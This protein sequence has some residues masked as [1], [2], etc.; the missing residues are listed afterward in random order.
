MNRN[1][2][3]GIGL[4]AAYQATNMGAA[5]MGSIL[6]RE[7]FLEAPFVPQFG[8]TTIL[9]MMHMGAQVKG[10]NLAIQVPQ[11]KAVGV[12]NWRK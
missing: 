11:N 6:S 5:R 3:L 8:I 10:F 12:P 2:L 9:E 1:L 4:E 7:F